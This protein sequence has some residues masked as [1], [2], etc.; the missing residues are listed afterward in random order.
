MGVQPNMHAA[1]VEAKK[2]DDV[3]AKKAIAA[4]AF[5]ERRAKEKAA[6]VDAVEKILKIIETQNVK[7]PEDI[8][9]V[10]D[11]IVN[12]VRAARSGGTAG[13]FAKM[14]GEDA[15][16]GDKVTLMDVFKR[17]FKSKADIDRSVRAWA[18]KGIIVEFKQNPTMLEST[19]EIKKMN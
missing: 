9:K 17:T 13:I 3:R 2:M 14:F 6:Q 18:E 12:P 11:G 8:M 15:K 7:V 19:Y 1:N 4:K 5:K 10:L 16:V